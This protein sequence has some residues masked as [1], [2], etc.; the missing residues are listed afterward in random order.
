MIN[1]KD[2]YDTV[3]RNESNSNN[4]HVKAWSSIYICIGK[5]KGKRGFV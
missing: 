1:I 4:C 2:L 5:G 3:C